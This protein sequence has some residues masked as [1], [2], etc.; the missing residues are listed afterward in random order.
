MVPV[1]TEDVAGDGLH[2]WQLY[3]AVRRIDLS[4]VDFRRVAVE[5]VVAGAVFGAFQ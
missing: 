3:P 4:D 5:C 1:A 2:G